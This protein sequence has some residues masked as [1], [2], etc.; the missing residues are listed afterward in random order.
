MRY[1]GL[2]AIF[3]ATAALTA[4][5]APATATTQKQQAWCFEEGATDDQKI[6]GCTAVIQSTRTSAAD[7]GSAL[8][9]RGVALTNKGDFDR[10]IADFT[11]AIHLNPAEAGV[12]LSNRCAVRTTIGQLNA[13]LADCNEAVR[14][15][16]DD[17]QARAVRGITYLKMGDYGHAI[18]DFDAA[19]A[20]VPDDAL[21]LFGRGI[22]KR[23]RG[24]E[25]GAAADMAA[26]RAIAADI[27]EYFVD[28]GVS[29]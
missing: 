16:P 23:A 17:P 25:A 20:E 12:A 29:I 9:N 3:L 5:V 6:A 19:L 21:S 1:A 11:L 13:A 22:A 14:L 10:A 28:C 26:A 18:T 27:E 4:G 2:H 24:D 7:R 15:T 8:M